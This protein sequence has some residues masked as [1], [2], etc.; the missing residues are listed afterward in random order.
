MNP[1]PYIVLG[2]GN[3]HKGIEMTDLLASTGI[4]MK[5][6]ADF[7][8]VLEIQEDGSTFMENARKKAV[9]YAQQLN[10]W[11]IAEDSG[12]SVP[13]LNGEPGIYSS[14]YSDPGATDERNNLLLIEK[15]QNFPIEKRTAFYSCAMVL[16]DPSGNICFETE[17]RCFGRILLKPSGTNGFGYDPLF[18]IV[19]Y[20]KTF[21]EID[22]LIKRSI[23][24]RARA[25]RQMI[26]I[27]FHLIAHNK[28]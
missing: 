7:P 25:T 18:E 15:L 24:H 22:P 3:R 20:H 6:L 11:I 12:L 2:S 26:P 5:T 9:G 27:L 1:N 17:G 4:V 19:E 23:S 8:K 28:L 16:V 13:I 14:R 10:E 21:G